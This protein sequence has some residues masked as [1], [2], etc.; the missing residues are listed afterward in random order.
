MCSVCQRPDDEP[1]MLVC[2]CKRGYHIYCLTPAL[3]AVPEGDWS[4]PVCTKAS[5][6][7]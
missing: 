5:C 2:D 7:S 4:C 6:S 1:N 3:E